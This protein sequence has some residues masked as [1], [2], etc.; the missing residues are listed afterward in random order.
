M[1]YKC[2]IVI[3]RGKMGVC[4]FLL[5]CNH[6]E[7][8]L[9]AKQCWCTALS[10]ASSPTDIFQFNHQSGQIGL[11][12]ARATTP[13]IVECPSKMNIDYFV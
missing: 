3:S 4:A 11:D 13:R 8:I 7:F 12:I 5:Q 1:S 2:N 6:S 10:S 9:N